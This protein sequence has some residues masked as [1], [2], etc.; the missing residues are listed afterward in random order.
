MTRATGVLALFGAIIAMTALN[1]EVVSILPFG[2]EGDGPGYISYAAALGVH[3]FRAVDPMWQPGYPFALWLLS[4]LF[5]EPFRAGVMISLVAGLGFLALCYLLVAERFSAPLGLLSVALIASSDLFVVS[6][7]SVNSDMTYGCLALGSIAVLFRERMPA[8]RRLAVAGLLAGAA[9]MVRHQA[10]MLPLLMALVL[11]TLPRGERLKA[12]LWGALAF[13][14]AALPV[15]V[16]YA[17]RFGNP[18]YNEHYLN[19]AGAAYFDGNLNLFFHGGHAAAY[20]SWGQVLSERPMAIARFLALNFWRSFAAL[21]TE[22]HAIPLLWVPAVVGMVRIRSVDRLVLLAALLLCLLSMSTVATRPR[23]LLLALP[24]FLPFA[25]DGA[26]WVY[27][28]ARAAIGWKLHDAVP[29]GILL[30]VFALLAARAGREVLREEDPVFRAAGL[31]LREATDPGDRAPFLSIYP[32]HVG[33]Y[34]ERRGVFLLSPRFNRPPY[35]LE[36]ANRALR[37]TIERNGAGYLLYYRFPGFNRP[38]FPH[39]ASAGRAPPFLEP[40]AERSD[41]LLVLYRYRPEL[42]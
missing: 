39:L 33:Y 32:F 28:R 34:A 30:A 15:L 6:A 18:L 7:C 22:T 40:L 1:R 16:A 42:R 12:G 14:L 21:L 31:L 27:G 26:V 8:A 17:L 3:G 5:A 2:I 13:S 20:D 36:A 9:Y 41:P 37:A 29:A 35:S 38:A 23:Y 19:L 4:P 25:V 11:P 10:L 24:F